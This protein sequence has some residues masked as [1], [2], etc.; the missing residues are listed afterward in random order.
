MFKNFVLIDRANGGTV[1][2]DIL[3]GLTVALALIP[4]A[5]AFA[6]V[7]GVS[8]IIGL[9]GAFLIGIVTAIFGGRP[10]MIS[11]ATGALAVVMVHLVREGEA[12]GAGL[13]VQFL[14]ATL[15]L[16]GLIQILFG[17]LKLGKFIRMVP[18]SVML[19]FVNGLAI[20]I[21]LSQLEMFQSN[22]HWLTGVELY[23]MLGLVLLTMAVMYFLPK[24]TNKVPPALVAILGIT[25]IVIVFNIDTATVKSFVVE[26][27]GDSI[28]AGLPVFALPQVS[29]LNIDNL[30]FMLPYAFILAV[31]GLV[32][33]LLTL[34]L[35]DELI[36]SHSNGNKECIAQGAANI[37]NGFFGG[38][39]GCAMIGQSIINVKSGGRG[40][41]S[42]I[43]ASVFLLLFIMFGSSYIELIPLAAL[44]GVMF[45]VVIGTFAWSSLKILTK[46]PLPDALVI[47]I[48]TAV[49]VYANL[50]VAVLT[51][52]IVSALVFA[53]KNSTKIRIHR[54]VDEHNIKHY[55]VSGPLFFASAESFI[56]RFDPKDDPDTVIID[57]LNA[58]VMDQSAIE[59]IN[60]VAERYLKENKEIHLRH[61]SSDC[62]AL[63]KKADDICEVN[64]L[65]DPDYFVA[66]DNYK[67]AV[68][69]K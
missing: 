24:I 69:S 18:H 26:R 60:K 23:T 39:G 31:I 22:H 59:A 8:P 33:S 36:G 14:F 55:E 47:I 34:N 2:N 17:I 38:M 62:I 27:G 68:K 42:A 6:F 21:F 5:I 25:L 56:N 48:V 15:L 37:T 29:F 65:E 54:L 43:T 49:T 20:V 46:I 9:Y 67:K 58:K 28:K 45:M 53:W 57:F 11:G 10:G 35:L 63:I 61:L 41:L 44:V 16:T 12:M 1:K 40:K 30:L 51:G 13:G 7:A 4:E 3:A 50:A 19:G 66:I 32:E 52:V 64:V